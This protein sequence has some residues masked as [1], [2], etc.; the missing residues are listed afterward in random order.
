MTKI[1]ILV[2][3]NADKFIADAQAKGII[4]FGRPEQTKSDFLESVKKGIEN[5]DYSEQVENGILRRLSIRRP[6]AL[7]RWV[8]GYSPPNRTYTFQRI[9][10]STNNISLFIFS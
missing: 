4:F 3:I 8:S 7:L 5:S 2:G 6:S 10:L 1:R 9:R